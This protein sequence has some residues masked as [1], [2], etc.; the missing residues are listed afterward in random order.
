MNED[1]ID[2]K[3]ML[4]DPL[5]G[6]WVKHANGRSIYYPCVVKSINYYV[7]NYVDGCTNFYAGV[8]FYDGFTS[9]FTMDCARIRNDCTQVPS[10]LTTLDQVNRFNK[11]KNS[12]LCQSSYEKMKGV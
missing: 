1:A 11:I 7:D 9:Y 10:P 4:S 3:S 6:V 8:S 5:I 2:L 12:V